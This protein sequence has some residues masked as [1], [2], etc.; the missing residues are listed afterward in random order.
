MI[1]Q[2]HGAGQRADHDRIAVTSKTAIKFYRFALIT[3]APSYSDSAT[4]EADQHHLDAHPIR[5]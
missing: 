3:D 1:D 5:S 2:L 4:H